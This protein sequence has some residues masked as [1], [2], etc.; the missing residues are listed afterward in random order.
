L[1]GVAANLRSHHDYAAVVLDLG[2]PR[3]GG[4]DVLKKSAPA[5]RRASAG[6]SPPATA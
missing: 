5:Q 1:D 2:L 4:L 3:L 6:S